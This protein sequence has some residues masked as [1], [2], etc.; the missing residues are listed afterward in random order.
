MHATQKMRNVI[1]GLLQRYA[2]ANVKRYLWDNEYRRGWWNCLDVMADDCL[3]PSVEKH[4]K[5]GSILDLGCGPGT[6]GNELNAAKYLFY[7]GVDISDVAIDKARKR[8]EKNR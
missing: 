7:T 3:Y 2:S 1:R 8:T 4:A 5:N 6:T